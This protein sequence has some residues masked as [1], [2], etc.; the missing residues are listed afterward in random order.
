[1]LRS[2]LVWSAV[3]HRRGQALVLVLLSTLITAA[4]VL[5]PLYAHAV[6]ESVVRATLD[7]ALVSSTGMSVHYDAETLAENG[8][9]GPTVLLPAAAQRLYAPDIDGEQASVGIQFTPQDGVA[10]TMAT[11]K[12]LCQHLRFV[13]GS[14]PQGANQLAVSEETARVDKLTV[15]ASLPVIPDPE[16]P[17]LHVV[18]PMTVVAVYARFDPATPYWFDHPYVGPVTATHQQPDALMVGYGFLDSTIK[19]LNDKNPGVQTD[20]DQFDDI[21]LLTRRVT[22]ATTALAL[23][24]VNQARIVANGQQTVLNTA[25]DD[26][27]NGTERQREEVRD[28]VPLFAGELVLL[29]VALLLFVVSAAATQRRPEVALARL[30]GQRPLAA[31]GLLVGEL[32]IPVLIG[33]PI[34]AVLAGA[35]LV[36]ARAVWLPPGVPFDI[37][38]PVLAALG[39]ALL[40]QLV[41]IALVARRLVREPVTMLLRRIPLRGTRVRFGVLEVG[42]TALALAGVL[43]VVSSGLSGPIAALAPGLLALAVGL[44]AGAAVPVL[45]TRIGPRALGAGRVRTGLAALQMARRPGTRG[46]FVLLVVAVASLVAA[47]DVWQVAAANRTARAGVEVG[48]GAVLQVQAG[49]AAQ[50]SSAVRQIDPSGHSAVP[51]AL[52]VPPNVGVSVLAMP[53]AGAAAVASW[54]WPSDRPSAAELARLSPAL[55]PTITLTGG[56]VEVRLGP[57]LVRG[58]RAPDLYLDL[59]G[60]DGAAG[61]Y[62]LGALPAKA[63]SVTYRR[64]L[65]CAQGCRL[66]GL[67]LFGTLLDSESRLTSVDLAGLSMHP[68]ADATQG[69]G[70][71]VALG[72]PADWRG[73]TA[74][75]ATAD[76]LSQ[77]D[78]AVASTTPFTSP[79]TY[80]AADVSAAAGGGLTIRAYSNGDKIGIVHGDVPLR[81]PALSSDLPDL[82]GRPSNDFSAGRL[83]GITQAY[84]SVGHLAA[85]PGVPG[86]AALVSLDLVSRLVDRSSTTTTYA[87][88]LQDGSRASIARQRAA[89]ARHGIAVIAVQTTSGREQDLRDSGAVWSLR[90]GLAAGLAGLLVALA[91]LSIGVITT[92]RSR[93]YDVAA[94]RLSGVPARVTADATVGEQVALSVVG[95]LVGAACGIGGARLLLRA[96]PY[97]AGGDG[98]AGAR[99]YTAWVVAGLAWVAALVLLAAVSTAGARQVTTG[100]GP[101]VVRDGAT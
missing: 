97:L 31:A 1:M 2:S 26:L 89:L 93:R 74:A 50:V 25:L 21:P 23:N 81:I 40:V 28:V 16:A 24:A 37:G 68:G 85:V 76:D 58:G 69:P 100:A 38:W 29:A 59:V 36:L 9:V 10:A 42:V 45:A 20:I 101:S 15:G 3:R 51:S 87:V 47:T 33:L 48:A 41:V 92:L 13:A 70:T 90:L 88:W 19:A 27:L 71:A 73:S 64:A 84:T 14:C 54:G 82:T 34:G 53:P 63:S 60:S 94:L 55:P 65:P 32:A 91:V 18:V 43:T 72:R 56:S 98:F 12:D 49:T 95:S 11:R 52:I 77:L 8:P 61:S 30:R 22:V 66:Q 78:Q 62:D 7:P 5:G 35:A 57:V 86:S 67:T 4:T 99:A 80:P 17:G 75:V 46:V 39:A 44:V 6:N 79:T 96:A 83:D